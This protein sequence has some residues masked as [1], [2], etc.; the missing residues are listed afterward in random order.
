MSIKTV[1]ILGAVVAAFSSQS[2]AE[3]Q[4][5]EVPSIPDPQRAQVPQMIQGKNDLMKFMEDA[6][7][8]LECHISAA[9]HNAMVDTM[10]KVAEKFNSSIAAFKARQLS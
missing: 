1:I 5:P 6:N 9:E 4:A 2:S 3:C 8:Y 10:N 7:A